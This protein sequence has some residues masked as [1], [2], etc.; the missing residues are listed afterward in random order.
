MTT[1]YSNSQIPA[2]LAG[3]I[4]LGRRPVFKNH[5]FSYSTLV[6]VIGLLLL[7]GCTANM[8]GNVKLEQK[9]YEAAIN[10]F[11]EELSQNPGNWRA[12]EKLGIAYYHVGQYNKAI[13]ELKRVLKETPEAQRPRYYLGLA[14]LKNGERSRAIE[15]FEAY[16]NDQIPAAEKEM[17]KQLT[18][19]Q[20]SDGIQLARQALAEEERLKTSPPKAGTVAVFYF[21]DI[22]PDN[23]LRPF[24]KAMATMIIADL[25]QVSSLQVLERLKVQ[26]LLR[27]MEL[28]NTGIVEEK[29]APRYG[30][31]LG[32]SNLI[33]GTMAPGSLHVQTAVASTTDEDAIGIIAVGSEIEQ[34]YILE[35][36]IVFNIL[37]VL[38]V[39]FTPVEEKKF[40][41]YHTEN[42]KAVVY[43][44]Q[45]LEALDVGEW[46]EAKG[47]FGQAVEEDPEFKLAILYREA[48]PNATAPSLGALGEMSDADL[49]NMVDAV[50]SASLDASSAMSD[51]GPADVTASEAP[52]SDSSGD[53]SISIG[54]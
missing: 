7:G 34:F 49:A 13:T 27:E 42:L 24:Q 48:C 46:K 52:S 25:S 36:E 50:I 11:L 41:Q 30:R 31:L 28:G 17:K 16:R 26:Y 19:L 2:F 51:V 37:K 47:F 33:V 22:S 21:E 39:K 40:S 15:V 53:G 35:K 1:F 29:T 43:F 8:A 45:G 3:T 5:S 12:R 20:I 14:L 32:A 23:S 4:Y 38:E 44:G 10:H 6:F 18:L 9:N 54:W